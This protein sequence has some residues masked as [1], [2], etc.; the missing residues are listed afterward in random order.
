MTKSGLLRLLSFKVDVVY[1]KNYKWPIFVANFFLNAFQSFKNFKNLPKNILY[2]WTQN[3]RQWVVV[4][5]ISMILFYASGNEIQYFENILQNNWC[6]FPKMRRECKKARLFLRLVTTLFILSI[7]AT[8][9]SKLVFL[10]VT[11]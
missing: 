10:I 3:P 1:I 4:S 2:I 9:V 7:H 11:L 6:H 5:C 8:I